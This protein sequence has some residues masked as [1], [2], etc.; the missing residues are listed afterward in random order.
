MKYGLNLLL[1]TGELHEAVLP[2][3]AFLKQIGYDGV[4]VPIFNTRLDYA[5]WGRRLD[6]LGLART[7]VTFRGADDNPISGDPAVRA[8][9]VDRMKGTLDCC[10]AAGCTALVG[11]YHSAYA[12]FTGRGPTADEWAWG[13]DTLRE[14]A[15]HS[16]TLG[17]TMGLEPLNRHETFLLNT[18]ADAARFCRDVN[19]PSCRVM[20][21]TYHAHAEESSPA[22]A[23]AAS[24][25]LLCHVHISE[26]HRGLPGSGQVRWTETFD[27][28]HTAG[29][30]GWLVVEAFGLALPELAAAT[31]TW[32]RTFP[33]ES[34][35]AAGALAFMRAAVARVRPL[36]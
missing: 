7:A 24:G 13:I 15:H 6:D 23:I 18:Q 16:Q 9:A 19:H 28:L 2:A 14:V 8:R 36:A 35:L 32:R 12:V 21:D 11:P 20:Y 1:W 31:R 27:A 4:E 30:D 5:A 33:S 29:Y 22:A 25:D 10:A 3:L 34:E 26:N 17:I